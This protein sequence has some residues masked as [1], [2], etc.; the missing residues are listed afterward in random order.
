METIG[1]PTTLGE[2]GLVGVLIAAVVYLFKQ[3]QL[4]M[5]NRIKD[6]KHK[7][8]NDDNDEDLT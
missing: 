8:Q 6:L 2:W 5:R 7:N 3:Y 4:A 1:I